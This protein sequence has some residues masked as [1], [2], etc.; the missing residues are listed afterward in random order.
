MTAG[1]LGVSGFALVMARA[2]QRTV[3]PIDEDVAGGRQHV[4]LPQLVEDGEH[5]PL[6]RSRTP[7]VVR[8]GLIGDQPSKRILCHHGLTIRRALL[9][10]RIRVDGGYVPDA[11]KA[12]RM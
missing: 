1:C 5:A 2:R 9:S 12:A 7:C 4:R 10:P 8:R 11:M 3:V 6:P